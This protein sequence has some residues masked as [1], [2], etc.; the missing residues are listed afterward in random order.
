MQGGGQTSFRQILKRVIPKLDPF[1]ESTWVVL[2]APQKKLGSTGPH[3]P[4][5]LPPTCS[6]PL[7][8]REGPPHVVGCLLVRSPCRHQCPCVLETL[9][10]SHRA[11][12]AFGGVLG[13]VPFV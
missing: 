5:D 9:R 7:A 12:G 10:A 6:K 2:K 1:S 4:S 13:W 3:P 11:G 8:V